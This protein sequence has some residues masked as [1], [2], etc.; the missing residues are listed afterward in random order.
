MNAINLL[1][2]ETFV[3]CIAHF[4]I[5]LTTRHQAR[6]DSHSL[7]FALDTRKV[8]VSMCGV[9]WVYSLLGARVSVYVWLQI[10]DAGARLMIT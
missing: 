1:K 4:T 6:N 5:P 8:S 9:Q 10:P 3:R 7:E 2:Y